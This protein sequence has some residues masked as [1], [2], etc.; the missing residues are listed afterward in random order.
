MA[1][2]LVDDVHGGF[3]YKNNFHVPESVDTVVVGN[4][5]SAL[6]LSYLLHGHVPYY[7]A[8]SHGPHPDPILHA[9]LSKLLES[10]Y[11]ALASPSAI[12]SLTEH[13]QGSRLSYSTQALPVNTLLDTLLRPNADTACG[14]VHSR[15]RWSHEPDK[16]VSHAVFGCTRR[17]GGQWSERS[18]LS[19]SSDF[20]ALS[21]AE[22]LSLPGYTFA[23]M[24]REKHAK[25][26]PEF[27][28]PSQSDISDYLATYPA[29]AGIEDSVYSSVHVDHVER[30]ASG[31]GFIVDI[32]R[33]VQDNKNNR[34]H[35][36][37]STT[38]HS[39]VRCRHLVLASGIFSHVIPS[40]QLLHPLTTLPKPPPPTNSHPL[41]VIGSGFSAAD[42][43]T[44]MLPC[45][46]IL[47]LFRWSPETHPSPLRSCH[48]QVYPEYAA[49]YR[50]MK[51][52]S[53]RYAVAASNKGGRGWK[54]GAAVSPMLI[55]RCSSNF[56]DRDRD[57]M[58][59]GLPNAE[60][61]EVN[62]DGGA[63]GGMEVTIQLPNGNG[64]IHRRV[65]GLEYL[66]GRRGSL[67][68]F[69]DSL[70]NAILS[71]S[72]VNNGPATS[73]ISAKTLRPKAARNL[74]VAPSVF[75]IGSLSGDSLIRFAFGGCVYAAGK[76][77]RDATLPPSVEAMLD[78]RKSAKKP[79]LNGRVGETA[80]RDVLVRVKTS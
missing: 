39:R 64:V 18:V 79:V 17:P 13:F 74:E 43:I 36:K 55:R 77:I 61:V 73:L 1:L 3:G 41:L 38:Y 27:T 67:N 30:S 56:V 54:I 60:I 51:L 34:G 52:A 24:Y 26:L 14:E 78:L 76:I 44:S 10:L 42:I 46:K 62:A 45:R 63:V 53:S 66:V 21:Y 6:I 20:E 28:R 31:E 40:P 22:M 11:S 12:D 58:Y 8:I 16:A 68:Y 9:K 57:S 7:D 75:V 15:I 47:H 2:C 19:S 65:S 32:S 69:S 37:G 33:T 25:P 70:K 71:E 4:G 50:R 49:I 48:R 59:E 80:D 35:V 23:D 5:P 72:P 29:R